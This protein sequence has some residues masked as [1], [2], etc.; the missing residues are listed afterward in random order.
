MALPFLRPPPS[1]SIR[2]SKGLLPAVLAVFSLPSFSQEV[3]VPLTAAGAQSPGLPALVQYDEANS[4][5]TTSRFNILIFGFWREPVLGGDGLLYDKLTFPG[6]ETIGQVGAPDLP[7]VCRNLAVGVKATNLKFDGVIAQNTQLFEQ[8][9]PLPAFLPGED[10]S[11]PD[12]GDTVGFE[13]KWAFDPG[14]YGSAAQWPAAVADDKTTVEPILGPLEGAAIEIRPVSYYPQAEL[15]EVATSMSVS[16]TA[17]G[18]S[19]PPVEITKYRAEEA[20]AHFSNWNAAKSSWPVNVIQYHARYLM[21]CDSALWDTLQPFVQHKKAQGY[22]VA[23]VEPPSSVSSIRQTIASWYQLGDPG[24][25]HYALLVGDTNRIPLAAVVVDSVTIPSDDPYGCVGPLDTSKEVHVGRISFDTEASLGAQLMKIIDYDLKPVGGADYGR[26]LLVSHKQGAPGKY[27]GSHNKVRTASYTNAPTF[28]SLFGETGTDNSDVFQEINSGVGVVAYRGHGSTLTWSGWNLFEESLEANAASTE[29]FN[30]MHNVVW[31]ISCTNSNI[32]WGQGTSSDCISEVWMEAEDGA[33]ASYGATVGTSTVPNHQLN[34]VLFQAVYNLGLTTHGKAIELAEASIWANYPGH[35]NPWAYLL[36]GDPSM[37][38]RTDK[39][40]QLAVTGALPS[41]DLDENADSMS[42]SVQ[43][44]LGDVSNGLVSVYKPAFLAG[45]PDEVLGAYWL[46]DLQEVTVPLGLSTPGELQLFVR[47][48]D[49]NSV[50]IEIP[51]PLGSAW[52]DLGQGT[53]G[54]LGAPEM[55]GTGSLLGGTPWS[56]LLRNARPNAS[57]FLCAGFTEL[58][59]PI[60]GGV[61]VPNILEP[62]LVVPIATDGFGDWKLEGTWPAGLASGITTYF[63]AWVADPTGE[64][65]FVGSNAVVAT[66]P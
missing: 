1:M 7:A 11:P 59:F 64:L 3:W 21:M 14:I 37:R 41:I 15:L 39:A 45:A 25:D 13:A 36:L 31:S 32:G 49:G 5:E 52:K 16:F 46:D 20:Q 27:S 9:R 29:T 56:V 63:Q 28:V 26:A 61:L 42:L 10:G 66:T 54:E 58:N 57:A 51:V 6:L 4:G 23:V 18:S 60:A 43:S 19:L 48:S 22:Q 34:E 53:T 50:Q 24:M 2:T 12:E 33:V 44:P 38:I 65:G 55:V 40:V 47:D 62:G 30:S 35:K 17:D 8:I